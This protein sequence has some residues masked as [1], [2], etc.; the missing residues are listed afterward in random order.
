M[1]AEINLE[2]A[3]SDD[4]QIAH[5]YGLFAPK[6]RTCESPKHTR[7]HACRGQNQDMHVSAPCCFGSRTPARKAGAVARHSTDLNP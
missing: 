5:N 3:G 7:P 6:R 4:E 1:I 2:E